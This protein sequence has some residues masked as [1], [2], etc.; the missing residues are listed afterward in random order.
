MIVEAIAFF[1]KIRLF[2]LTFLALQSINKSNEKTESKYVKLKSLTRHIDKCF[3]VSPTSKTIQ[4][5][6][7]PPKISYF[8]A[9]MSTILNSRNI[10]YKV[11]LTFSQVGIRRVLD[12][13]DKKVSIFVMLNLLTIAWVSSIRSENNVFIINGLNFSL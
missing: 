2:L 5:E 9:H 1:S 8:N 12:Y 13:L 7:N 6:I 11:F 3:Y 4:K 10:T